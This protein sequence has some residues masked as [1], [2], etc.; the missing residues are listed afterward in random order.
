MHYYLID[1]QGRPHRSL[2][3]DSS[4]GYSSTINRLVRVVDTREGY[5][6]YLCLVGGGGGR[7]KRMET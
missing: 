3:I 6:S 5:K 1:K 7:V 4:D 2:D